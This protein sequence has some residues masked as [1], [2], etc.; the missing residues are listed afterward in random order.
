MLK[1]KCLNSLM[2]Y[3][4]GFLVPSQL[5]EDDP[6]QHAAEVEVGKFAQQLTGLLQGVGVLSA[7]PGIEHFAVHCV[8]LIHARELRHNS[9]NGTKVRCAK[10][11]PVKAI[12]C[13]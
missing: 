1:R 13:R 7:G 4:L 10:T 2:E 12:L 3:L 5:I 8:A 6:L 11:K 9:T